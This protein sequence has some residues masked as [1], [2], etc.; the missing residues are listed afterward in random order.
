MSITLVQQNGQLR[1]LSSSVPIPEGVPIVLYTKEEI[2]DP[3]DKAALDS[4]FSD[5]EDWGTSLDKLVVNEKEEQ[6]P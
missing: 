3:W 1:L 6:R 5:E 4:F 2:L